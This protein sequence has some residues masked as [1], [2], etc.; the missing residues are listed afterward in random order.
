[1]KTKLNKYLETLESNVTGTDTLLQS[2]L[3]LVKESIKNESEVDEIFDSIIEYGEKMEK[4]GYDSGYAQ[5][6]KWPRGKDSE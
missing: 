2:I 4:K 6:A 5:S 1:M 3:K